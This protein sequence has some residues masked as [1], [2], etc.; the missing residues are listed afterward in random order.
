MLLIKN[1]CGFIQSSKSSKNKINNNQLISAALIIGKIYYT[2]QQM[3]AK[4]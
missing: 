3:S 1:K 2:N 4:L